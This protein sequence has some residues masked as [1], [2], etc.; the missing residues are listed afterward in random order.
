MGQ[1]LSMKSTVSN[2]IRLGPPRGLMSRNVYSGH[3]L[4]HSASG[5][6]LFS[7]QSLFSNQRRALRHLLPSALTVVALGMFLP[8]GTLNIF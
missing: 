4:Y 5:F 8:S 7:H 2:T 1:R 6:D 3:F